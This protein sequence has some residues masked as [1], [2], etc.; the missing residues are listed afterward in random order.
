LNISILNLAN[1]MSRALTVG[2]FGARAPVWSPD[3]KSL[4]FVWL[5]PD[6]PGMYRKN[7]NGVGAEQLILPFPGVLWPYQWVGKDLIYFAGASGANDVLMMSPDNPREQIPLINSPYNDVDGAVSPDGKWFLYSSNETGRWEIYATTF[8]VSST[9]IPVTMHGG[10][11]PLWGRDGK[12]LFYV[13]PATAELISV[14]VTPGDP[15]QFGA[16]A[17]IYPGPLEYPSGHSYDVDFK[18]DRLLVAPTVAPQGDITVL[19][20]WHRCRNKYK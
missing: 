1:G 5:R 13:K 18:S 7:A 11:D 14:Q 3:G 20:N 15:P 10:T 19:L 4:V 9:K 16:H 6:A 12:K 17:R 2:D 8:P